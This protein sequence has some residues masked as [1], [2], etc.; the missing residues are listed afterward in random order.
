MI[1]LRLRLLVID[2]IMSLLS[3]T[4]SFKVCPGTLLKFCFNEHFSIGTPGC[5]SK[6]MSLMSGLILNIALQSA[7]L[8]GKK[9]KEAR[10]RETKLLPELCPLN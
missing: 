6:S 8:T 1:H 3:S 4:R 9:Q 10:Q 7:T 2:L 5:F